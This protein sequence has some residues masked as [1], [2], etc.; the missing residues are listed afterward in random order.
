M[1]HFFCKPKSQIAKLLDFIWVVKLKNRKAAKMNFS[2][3]VPEDCCAWILLSLSLRLYF[4]KPKFIF[5]P[6]ELCCGKSQMEEFAKLW[7]PLI[8]FS[9]KNLR[10]LRKKKR[11]GKLRHLLTAVSRNC[12]YLVSGS[13]FYLIIFIL[14]ENTQVFRPQLTRSRKPLSL[15][16]ETTLKPTWCPI[17]VAEKPIFVKPR[18]MFDINWISNQTK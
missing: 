5:F 12:C 16:H 3:F 14:A 8:I 15:A 2:A 10:E 17:F 6:F 4:V 13:F 7:F 1:L 18:L 9:I 11:C